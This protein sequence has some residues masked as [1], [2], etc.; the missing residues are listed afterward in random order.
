MNARIFP[1]L[2]LILTT[3]LASCDQRGEVRAVVGS[4]LSKPT[5]AARKAEIVRQLA[6]RCPRPLTADEAE[7][8]AEVVEQHRDKGVNY[9]A[10]LLL[11]MNDQTLICR[12]LPLRA[13][14]KGGA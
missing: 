7:W 5:P 1:L 3:L 8:V 6:P 9:V 12:G 2:L 14:A 4:V 13:P 10:G 11:S